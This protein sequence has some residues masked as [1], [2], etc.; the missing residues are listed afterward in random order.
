MLLL[1]FSFHKPTVLIPGQDH[2]GAISFIIACLLCVTLSAC[3]LGKKPELQQLAPLPEGNYCSI[4]VLP[5]V[6]ETKYIEGD[7]I[8]YRIFLTELNRTPGLYTAQEGDVR[9]I[10]RQMAI[11][12]KHLPDIEGIKILAA[13]LD[14]GIVVTGAIMVME[15]KKASNLMEPKLTVR[16]NILDGETGRIIWTTYYG[17]KGSD[18]RTVMH[19][20]VINTITELSRLI[21]H[22]IIQLWLSAGLEKCTEH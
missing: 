10:F 1:Q 2:T 16:L 14:A 21:S 9:K 11:P 18:Y 19:F 6:N 15:E 8:L 3:S 4:V 22:D 12:R 7:T 20:G 5:F 13:R 17:K